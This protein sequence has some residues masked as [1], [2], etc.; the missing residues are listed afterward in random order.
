MFGP[1]SDLVSGRLNHL[2]VFPSLFMGDQSPLD[3]YVVQE[4]VDHT[5]MAGVD[6]S[7]HLPAATHNVL[8]IESHSG[9]AAATLQLDLFLCDELFSLADHGVPKQKKVN[10]FIFILR[11]LCSFLKN[12]NTYK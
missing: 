7:A 12:T 5:V 9:L 1:N 3:E 4:N 11:I 6:L 8:R 2:Q 10:R